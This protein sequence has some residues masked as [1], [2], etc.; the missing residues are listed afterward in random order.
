MNT[1]TTRKKSDMNTNHA[2]PHGRLRWPII[3]V[4]AVIAAVILYALSGATAAKAQANTPELEFLNDLNNG[5]LVVYDTAQALRTGHWICGQLD[6]RNG[7][8]VANDIWTQ[9]SWSDVP[10]PEYALVWVV[11]AAVDLCP[12]N[13]HPARAS[14]TTT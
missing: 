5:G 7:A 10:S 6:F 12:W 9:T 4:A 3:A 8:A 13:Y 14:S 11:A 2:H 1:T